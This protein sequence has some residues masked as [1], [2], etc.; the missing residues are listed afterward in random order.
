MRNHWA[1]QFPI[2]FTVR[3][4]RLPSGVAFDLPVAP[5]WRNGALR[6]RM[7]ETKQLQF[8]H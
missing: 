6:R 7:A 5:K 1:V 2:N 3:E 4:G 8:R